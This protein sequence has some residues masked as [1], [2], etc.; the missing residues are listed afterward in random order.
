VIGQSLEGRAG[1]LPL[2]SAITPTHNGSSYV[3]ETIE[4]VLAQDY[5]RIE[6]IVADDG[7]TDDTP[8][9]LRRYRDRIRILRLPHR[10]E[11]SAR[12]AAIGA[13]TGDYIAFLD[14]D[15]LWLPGKISRQ[16]AAF[17][18]HPLAGLCHT[19]YQR[20]D[21]DGP[22]RAIVHPD[23]SY[24]GRCFEKE[25]YKNGIGAL[26]VMVRRNA[27]PPHVFQ[28]DIQITADY[29]LWLDILYEREAI[30]IPTVL[31]MH[32]LHSGQITHGRRQRWKIYEAVSRMRLLARVRDRMS[33]AQHDALRRWTIET[34]REI[35]CELRRQGDHGW[36]ALG[37]HL[38]RKY[39]QP[40][41]WTDQ[42]YAAVYGGL[43]RLS[44]KGR[45]ERRYLRL[46]R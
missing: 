44:V 3:A 24:Q 46:P 32:R 10:G 41:S 28:E 29:A 20:F 2:V 42:L 5:P 39:G 36:A 21:V 17:Q 12:N 13:C 16:V 8:E 4:S 14:H 19:G 31:A 40:V 1:Y 7:S 23:G 30:Y 15:D 38:L 45:S 25:F 22:G 34:L 37:L 43:H 27:L 18:A 35:T 6:T 9:I 11:N 26:T 33:E